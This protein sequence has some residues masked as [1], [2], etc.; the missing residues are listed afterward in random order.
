MNEI[1]IKTFDK[2]PIFACKSYLISKDNHCLLIDCGYFSQELKKEIES[3]DYFD[4]VVLTHKHFDHIFGLIELLK[5]FPNT[6]IYSHAIDEFFTNSQLNCS[7]FMLEKE[8]IL[9]IKSINLI[10]GRNEIGVF[11]IDVLYTPG[12]TSDSIIFALNTEPI[13]FLGDTIFL[14]TIGR[15]DLLSSSPEQ[16]QK[17][18]LKAKKFLIKKDY[19]IFCGHGKN[20]TSKQLF[21]LN[22]YIK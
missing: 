8:L 20:G 14:E 1:T 6:K 15:T 9:N 17:S 4:G 11:T 3:Y 21:S 12:H 19:Q 18:L 2:A 22:P 7:Y 13:A 10:E 16:M 5:A